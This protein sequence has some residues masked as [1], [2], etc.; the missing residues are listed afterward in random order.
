MTREKQWYHHGKQQR[1]QDGSDAGGHGFSFGGFVKERHK[2]VVSQPERHFRGL[3]GGGLSRT[4][5]QGGNHGENYE[6]NG[7][8]LVF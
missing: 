8:E 7:R 5:R 6:G 2:I 4:L 3:S 1:E